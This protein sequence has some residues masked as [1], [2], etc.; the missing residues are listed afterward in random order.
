V[1]ELKES[2]KLGSN[3]SRKGTEVVRALPEESAACGPEKES[4]AV[5]V[6]TIVAFI[7]TSCS[8]VIGL[9]DFLSLLG[10]DLN[11]WRN[12]ASVP[13]R[14]LVGWTNPFSTAGT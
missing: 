1:S 4:I 10:A 6:S 9:L 14:M 2:P 11:S 12:P 7:S 8:D 5:R 13:G 3:I